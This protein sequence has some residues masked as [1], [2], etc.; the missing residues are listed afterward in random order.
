MT[1]R[2]IRTIKAISKGK[3]ADGSIGFITAEESDKWYN[4]KDE[5]EVLQDL[6]DSVIQK[7][8]TIEFE[9]SNGFAINFT[10]KEKAKESSQ[11][12]F[13]DDLTTFEDLLNDAHDKF[14]G[15]FSI[16]T[17]MIENDWEKQRA[18]FKATIEILKNE[19]TEDGVETTKTVYEAYGDAT[20][21]NCGEMVKK[22]YIRMAETRSIARALRWA[23]NN[24]KAAAEETENGELPDESEMAKE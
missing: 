22:H 12:N 17:E 15:N 3:L 7:G 11:G 10:L 16:K 9:M 8:N 14:K 1:D 20:Q 4:T 19:Y 21:D 6:I 23:T 2:L 13:A 24:A 5:P 18:I